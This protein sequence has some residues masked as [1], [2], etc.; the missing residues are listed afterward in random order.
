MSKASGPKGSKD[1]KRPGAS[2]NPPAPKAASSDMQAALPLEE[3]FTLPVQ[4]AGGNGTSTAAKSRGGKSAAAG[5]APAKPGA[6]GSATPTATQAAPA[7]KAG[8]AKP[9]PAPA[10]KPTPAPAA[11][12]A[13]PAA[14]AAGK[15]GAPAAPAAPVRADKRSSPPPAPPEA[16]AAPAAGAEANPAA[17]AEATAAAAAAEQGPRVLRYVNNVEGC[18]KELEDGSRVELSEREWR[19]ALTRQFRRDAPVSA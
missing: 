4:A 11:K 19:N 15:G 2:R 3:D 13:T 16:P 5:K 7:G 18:W 8:A 17:G 12:P 9:T 1:A 14:K 6:K 10:A